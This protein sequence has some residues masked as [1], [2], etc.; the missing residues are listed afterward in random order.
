MARGAEAAREAEVARGAEAAR[1]AEVVKGAAPVR[2]V[3]RGAEVARE[4]ELAREAALV[5]AA[6]VFP[7]RK[8]VHLRGRR[9]P[10][11]TIHLWIYS[12]SFRGGG[13]QIPIHQK[14]PLPSKSGAV[15]PEE[16]SL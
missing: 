1:E 8:A 16:T 9:I 7:V 13:R 11:R 14:A 3:A 4:T 6:K 2:E 12:L 10:G 15:C 5:K